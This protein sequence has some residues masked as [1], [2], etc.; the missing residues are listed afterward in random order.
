MSKHR[1]IA[2]SAKPKPDLWMRLIVITKW[3]IGITA[4]IALLI[5]IWARTF[6]QSN[7]DAYHAGLAIIGT[8]VS[9]LALLVFALFMQVL[10]EKWQRVRVWIARRQIAQPP[11]PEHYTIGDDG[12]IVE[13]DTKRKRSKEATPTLT[14]VV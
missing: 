11:L 5:A 3:G 6:G 12:E 14:D 2:R 7:F 1:N 10:A 8:A 9:L 13:V 4:G